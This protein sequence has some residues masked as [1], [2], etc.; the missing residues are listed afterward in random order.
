MEEIGSAA[1]IIQKIQTTV[2]GGYRLTLD[3]GADSTALM[4]SL[5]MLKGSGSEMIYIGIAKE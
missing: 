1:A 4:Q 3:L 5:L 2:D